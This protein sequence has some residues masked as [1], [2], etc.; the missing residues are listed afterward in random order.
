MELTLRRVDPHDADLH[1]L[2]DAL[3]ADLLTR[4]PAEEI[5]KVDFT[6]PK[7]RQMWFSVAYVDGEPA[8][9]GGLRPLDGR[10]MELKRFYV[11]DKY[12]KQGVASAIIRHLEQQASE[13]GYST[14]LLETGDGQPE[15]L[16]FYRKH[17][18]EVVDRF[19]E[20]VDCEFSICMGKKI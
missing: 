19:G 6:D 8:G 17:G 13:R 3:D 2:I 7:V 16:A 5:F 12:R 4:Y 10:T 11:A 15:A 14:F 1:L 18:Y 9:C 20:Y